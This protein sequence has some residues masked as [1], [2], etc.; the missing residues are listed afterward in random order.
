[1]REWVAA[2][3][4]QLGEEVEEEAVSDPNVPTFE[5]VIGMAEA[6]IEGGLRL[7][8]RHIIAQDL[9]V[10]S[11]CADGDIGIIAHAQWRLREAAREAQ[12]ALRDAREALDRLERKMGMSK[13]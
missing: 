13:P 10:V 4:R 9:D 7:L 1:M 11:V 12:S 3:A 6:E 5:G 8:A 2:I